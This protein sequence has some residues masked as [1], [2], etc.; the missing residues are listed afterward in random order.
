MIPIA[1]ILFY[2][3]IVIHDIP[4]EIAKQIL[5]GG[6]Y[7][8]SAIYSEHFSHVSILRKVILRMFYWMSYFFPFH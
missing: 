7:G 8:Q 6:A 2:G 1:L 4:Y 5:P 3:I